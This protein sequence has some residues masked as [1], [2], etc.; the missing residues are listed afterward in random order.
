MD[1]QPDYAAVDK[2]GCYVVMPDGAIVPDPA[3]V[4]EREAALAQQAKGAP[5]AVVGAANGEPPAPPAVA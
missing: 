2:G 1:K 3:W 5:G 4:A